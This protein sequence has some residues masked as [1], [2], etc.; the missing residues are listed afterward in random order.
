MVAFLATASPLNRSPRRIPAWKRR[1][2]EPKWM[3][4]LVAMEE[5]ENPVAVRHKKYESS[6]D[7]SPAMQ[8]DRKD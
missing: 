7:E 8:A 6:S 1:K 5:R 4:D 3:T 2:F